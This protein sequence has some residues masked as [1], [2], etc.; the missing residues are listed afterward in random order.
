MKQLALYLPL[1]ILASLV[2]AQ[3]FCVA[4]A[5]AV[6]PVQA[7]AVTTAA[8]PIRIKT[9]NGQ[10]SAEAAGALDAYLAGDLP[11]ASQAYQ[12][13]LAQQPRHRAALLGMATI[14]QRQEQFASAEDYYLRAIEADPHDAWAQAGLLNLKALSEPLA[15]ESRLKSLSHAQP[16]V[17]LPH[18]ALGNLYAVH[19]RW[20]EAMRAYQRAVGADPGNPDALFNLA[21]GLDHLHQPTLAASYYKQALV[22]AEKRPAA[23]SKTAIVARLAE[24]AAA[25][26]P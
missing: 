3:L 13:V 15:A 22:A 24:L 6:D 9:R 10:F 14:A 5:V 25:T 8:P 21:I 19:G 11:L 23:A 12:S 18:F 26:A 2:A 7:R 16:G 1:H 4:N 17:F 20:N